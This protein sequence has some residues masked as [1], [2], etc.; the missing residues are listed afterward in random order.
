[1][2]L[3]TKEK[4]E[5][6]GEGVVTLILLLLLNLAITVI[7][8]QSIESNPGLRDGIFIIKQSVT[9]GPMHFHLLSWENLFI[10]AMGVIDVII[11]Y[12]RLIR[13]YH[14]MQLRHIISE[15]HYIANGH[16]D[17]RIPFE[18]K[19]DTERVIQSINALVDSVIESMNDE[20]KVEVSKDKLVT[21]VSHDLR[22]PLTSILGYLGLIEDGQCKNQD[23]ILKYS[24]IAYLKAQQMKQL[25]DRL[26]EYAK[27][28]DKSKPSQE[29][30]NIDV[31]A[32]LEQ[33]QASFKLDASKHGMSIE[34]KP[35]KKNVWIKANAESLGRVF[36]NL[37][38]NAFK[39]GKGGKHIY[40]SA[41]P[42]GK[43]GVEIVVANDGEQIP[44]RSL[45]HIFDRFYRVEES[46]NTKTG[47]TGL[48][49]AIVREIVTNQ[50][51][52]INVSSTKKL[53]AF[54]IYLPLDVN[55]P[56]QKNK[57]MVIGEE[58][59]KKEK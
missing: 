22:T 18:L 8:T 59:G 15:L 28:G 10:V 33:L 19:G 23:E 53:T 5:L 44:K 58:N 11:I 2:N 43:N 16:F 52:Y 7:I 39:Y 29:I 13:R 20:R 31:N 25:V 38:S 56:L 6:F 30:D 49:L 41:K 1:M 50:G 14:Q 54:K 47:G 17:H 36:N 55:H 51:G 34:M 24:H 21:S 48:G 12:W 37:I 45:E 4:T 42:E 57:R 40:L 32:L 35:L 26:F 9:F 46:R 3:T 27:A